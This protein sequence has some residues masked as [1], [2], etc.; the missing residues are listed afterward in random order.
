LIGA[1]EYGALP[2]GTKG[3]PND[4]SFRELPEDMDHLEPLMEN[5]INRV[6]EL[7]NAEIR[8][9]TTTAESFTPDNMYIM[10]E[11]PGMKKLYTACGMNSSGILCGA[12]VG[13]K[14]AEWIV[15]G[16]PKSGHIMAQRPGA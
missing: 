1:F 8:R 6:P 2:Y 7:M 16:Y 15:D 4:W 11:A 9:I 12:G 10:G 3:I 14:T 13:K 5:A